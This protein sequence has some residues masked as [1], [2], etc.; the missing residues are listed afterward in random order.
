[1]HTSV[2]EPAQSESPLSAQIASER[3]VELARKDEN[4]ATVP[5][6][7]YGLLSVLRSYFIFDVLIWSYTV[8]LGIVSIPVSLFG[9][10]SRIL[11]GF[12]RFWSWLI[13]KTILSPV[14]VTGLEK[15]DTSKTHVYAVTHASALDI[16]VLY[17]NLPFEFRILFKK[18]L[19]SYP[20]VGWHLR[21]SGQVCIDQQKPTR[22]IAHIRSAVKSL[23][24]GMPLVIFPEGGRTPDGEIKPFMPG[25][26]YLAIKAQADIV[27]I[28][29]V[30]TFELLPMNTYHIKPRPLE[31]RVGEPI[32]TLGY[33]LREMEALS[34]KVHQAME[35]L[36]YR[37]NAH[38]HPDVPVRAGERSSP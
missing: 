22:S 19:L 16:P 24:A 20:I 35:D 37:A 18:E 9:E 38:V 33:S 32:P 30:G 3:R 1:M 26:F 7:K 36:Y 28:A 31:M 4:S 5:A 29:L 15:I 14:K 23:Q 8:I 11:H 34:E 10:K 2:G 17:V 13:M 21:R 27:P 12:A 25:A 6:R